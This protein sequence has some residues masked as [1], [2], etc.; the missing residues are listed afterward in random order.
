MTIGPEPMTRTCL[1]SC[2]FG[3]T[4]SPLL[5]SRERACQR[6]T[7]RLLRPFFVRSAQDA[8]PSLAALHHVDELIE[9]VVRVV[10]AGGRLGVVLHREGPPVH[11]PDALDHPVVGAR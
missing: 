1:R 3:I 4:S 11:E 10:R 7:R 2:R 6:A 8:T 9:Q 5:L